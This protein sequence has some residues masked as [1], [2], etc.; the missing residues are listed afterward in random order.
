MSPDLTDSSNIFTKQEG[1]GHRS[2]KLRCLR[3]S[4]P[5]PLPH[6]RRLHNNTICNSSNNNSSCTISMTS[7]GSVIYPRTP[8]FVTLCHPLHPT[9]ICLLKMIRVGSWVTLVPRNTF[10][11]KLP[12]PLRNLLLFCQNDLLLPYLLMQISPD[13][14]LIISA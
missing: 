12:N 11:C 14:R 1:A 5:R 4:S 2:H 13:H 6:P 7:T 8:F 9:R 3:V 10:L